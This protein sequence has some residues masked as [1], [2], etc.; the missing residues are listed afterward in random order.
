[1]HGNHLH[2]NDGGTL[3]DVTVKTGLAAPE[4]QYGPLWSAEAPEWTSTTMA[5]STFWW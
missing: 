4:P 3:T 1:V 5:G 2:H